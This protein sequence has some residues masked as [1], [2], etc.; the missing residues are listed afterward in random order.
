MSFLL[1]FETELSPIDAKIEE[2]RG[3][4]DDTSSSDIMKQIEQLEAQRNKLLKNIYGNLGDWQICQVARHPQRPQAKDYIKSIITDFVELAG[5]RLFA[6]DKAIICGIGRFVDTPVIVCGHQKGKDTNEKITHNFGMPRPE[7]YRKVLR[8]MDLAD[9]FKLPIINLIDTPGAYP[10]IGAEERGQSGAIGSCL[11][12]TADLTVPMITV[13]IGEGG[14]GGALAMACGDY[15][16]MMEFSIYSVIS[17]EGCASILWKDASKMEA[18]AESLCLTSSKL[19][20]LGLIDEI[21]QE[22]LGAAHR[23]YKSTMDLI[24]QSIQKS[25]FR[26]IQYDGEELIRI[27]EERWSNY[28]I[29]KT[30]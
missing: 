19:K 21:I 7:G 3:N 25:L 29:Y 12:R 20:K 14:S 8:M 23:D 6:E 27:R 13:I 2:L 30:I 15:T 1:N 5:D 4:D 22:P 9:K 11:R 17:P 16:A 26:L 24:S 10:G 28:G 18:A